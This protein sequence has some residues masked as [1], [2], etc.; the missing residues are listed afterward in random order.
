MTCAPDTMMERAGEGVETSLHENF[1]FCKAVKLIAVYPCIPAFGCMSVWGEVDVS[2]ET[3]SY[4][5]AYSKEKNLFDRVVREV[6]LLV[7]SFPLLVFHLF[8]CLC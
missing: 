5:S 6:S 7:R 4:P 3:N 8:R 1:V 2:S